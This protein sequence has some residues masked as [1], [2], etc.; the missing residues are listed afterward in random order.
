MNF[1]YRIGMM[2][3]LMIHEIQVIKLIIHLPKMV[4]WICGLQGIQL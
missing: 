1:L 2:H 4:L 3:I